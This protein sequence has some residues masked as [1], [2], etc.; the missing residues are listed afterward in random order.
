[1]TDDFQRAWASAK[2]FTVSLYE[3]DVLFVRGTV[4]GGEIGA[5][6]VLAPVVQ[7]TRMIP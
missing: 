5:T 2:S 7:Q 4:D 6:N 1:M 3:Q